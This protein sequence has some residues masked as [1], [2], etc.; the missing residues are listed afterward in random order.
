MCSRKQELEKQ[1]NE[2]KAEKERQEAVERQARLHC[3]RQDDERRK[4]I[5]AK[6][7]EIQKREIKENLKVCLSVCLCW[8]GSNISQAYR[9]RPLVTSVLMSCFVQLS[10]LVGY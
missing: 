9:A 10:A 3:Q 6:L 7:E 5:L 8:R 4:K 1:E 2:K